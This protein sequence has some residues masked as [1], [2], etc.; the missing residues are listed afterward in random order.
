MCRNTTQPSHNTATTPTTRHGII[1][2][3]QDGAQR[4]GRIGALGAGALD[5]RRRAHGR[6]VRG[7]WA[8]DTAAWPA[9]GSSS[10]ATT[11][12]WAGQDTATRTGPGRGLYALAGPVWV[13]STPNS[14]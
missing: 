9:I 8:C 10:P 12:R 11:R 2:G 3:E 13:L 4:R 1:A 14:L 7:H 6:W 5:A